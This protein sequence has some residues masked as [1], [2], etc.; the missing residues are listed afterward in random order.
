MIASTAGQFELALNLPQAI[1]YMLELGW[2]RF[3][4]GVARSI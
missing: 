2:C 4:G 3:S 1:V